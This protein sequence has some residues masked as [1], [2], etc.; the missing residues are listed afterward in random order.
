MA[1][2]AHAFSI[3][4]V[5]SADELLQAQRI[6]ESVLEKEQGF[7][8]TVNVDGHDTVADHVLVL[9]GDLPVGTGRLAVVEP[10][11]GIIARIALLPDY[12]GFGLGER[13]IRRLEATAIRRGLHTVRVEPHADLEKFFQRLGYHRVE[14]PFTRGP[15]TLIRMT[16]RLSS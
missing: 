14:E 10:G 3:K 7:G 4:E 6:R 16:K 11:Q 8:H 9:E 1:N 5:H 2:R 12:R 13:L 15:H